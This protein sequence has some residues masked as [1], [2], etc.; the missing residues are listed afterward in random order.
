M[1]GCNDD[2]FSERVKL[3]L[4]GRAVKQDSEN[5]VVDTNYNLETNYDIYHEDPVSR[6]K[7]G[8]KVPSSWMGENMDNLGDGKEETFDS[9]GEVDENSSDS[10]EEFLSK[11]CV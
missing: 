5:D 3:A 8:I 6:L 1:L 2:V 4:E 7:E 11:Y 9:S 10:D